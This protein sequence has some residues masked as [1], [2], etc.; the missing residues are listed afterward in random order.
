MIISDLNVMGV[1]VSPGKANPPLIVD[2]DAVLAFPV[3]YELFQAIARWSPQ[4]LERFRR[5]H[6]DQFAQGETL[7]VRRELS[8]PVTLPDAFRIL[9]AKASDHRW[10]SYSS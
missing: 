10:A 5:V 1:A 3:P 7:Q 4:V 9:V 2:A 6:H 8:R